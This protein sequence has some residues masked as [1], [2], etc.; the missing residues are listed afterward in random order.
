MRYPAEET[1]E[2]HERIL[3][4]ASQMFRERGFE[5]VTVAEVM[6]AAGLTHGAFYSHFG[7]KEAL[8]AEA[9]AY[10]MEITRK[11]VKKS[12]GEKKTRAAYIERYMSPRHRDN[13]SEGCT[14]AALSGAIRN[15]PEVRG[16]FTA[17][18]KE[19]VEAMGGDRGEAMTTLSAMVGAMALARAVEDDAFSREILSEVK[20]KITK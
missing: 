17:E 14:M 6:K 11:G 2:K 13:P 3:K 19:I 12:F 9:T 5:D 16:T 1:A 8:M 20:A 15:E 18:L 10:G 4:E 7:S